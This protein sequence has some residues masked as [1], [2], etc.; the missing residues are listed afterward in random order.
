MPVRRRVCSLSRV[1]CVSIRVLLCHHC[2]VL[3]TTD[4]GVGGTRHDVWRL[5]QGLTIESLFEDRFNTFVGTGPERERP[6]TGRFEAL[7]A[8]AFAQPHDP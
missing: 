8:V 2:I 7:G 1:G 5:R 4:I 6:P 3:G